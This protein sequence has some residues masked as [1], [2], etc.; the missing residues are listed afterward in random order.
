VLAAGSLVLVCV[1]LRSV[2]ARD[3]GVIGWCGDRAILSRRA[4]AGRIISHWLSHSGLSAGEVILAL[5]N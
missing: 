5:R 1:R 3:T 2:V 4:G